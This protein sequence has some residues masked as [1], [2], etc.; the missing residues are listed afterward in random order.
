LDIAGTTRLFAAVNGAS[1][2]IT[3][4]NASASAQTNLTLDGS[5]LIF[6]TLGAE[7]ARIDSS[8]NLGIGTSSPVTKL[9]VRGNVFV[10]TTA[11]GNNIVAFGNTVGVGPLSGAPDSV[12]GN[13]FIVGESSTASGYPGF[14]KFYTTLS[15]SVSERM[16]LDASGNLGLGVTPSAWNTVTALQV[17]NASLGGYSSNNYLSANA[18]YES[19][20]KYITSNRAL[21]YIQ[22]ADA[23]QHQWFTAASGTAGNAISFTQA[24]TLDASGNWMAGTTTAIGRATVVGG[25]SQLSFHDGNGSNTNYGY[26]NYGGSSG[27]LTLNANS[28]GGN[29][30]IRFLTSNGGANAE[31]VRIDYAGSLGLGGSS[32]GSGALVMFIANATTA[33]TTN[34]TGGGVLYVEAGALKYRGSSGTVTTIANA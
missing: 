4:L 2:T 31:R 25:S 34:P 32:F 23:G 18:Y 14:L 24:M 20:W 33:P 7:K 11:S 10:G 30:A 1:P 17:K 9:D 15:G 28:T 3:A 22:E 26:L 19:A 27:E 8:G 16:R 12:Q 29:T 5:A 13:S 21:Q 6:S